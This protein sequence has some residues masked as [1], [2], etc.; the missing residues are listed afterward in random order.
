ML[1]E[2]YGQQF[3]AVQAERPGVIRCPLT[4]LPV[5]EY[6]AGDWLLTT[7]TGHAQGETFAVP[8]GNFLAQYKML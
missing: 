4:K 1:C 8:A 2:A 6:A 7:V 5:R 3:E